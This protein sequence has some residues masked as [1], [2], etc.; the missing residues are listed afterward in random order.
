MPGMT[1][2]HVV[3][4]A[5]SFSLVLL[6]LSGA[7]ARAFCPT[8]GLKCGLGGTGVT[9]EDMTKR[10]MTELGAEFFGTPHQTRAMR[11]AIEETAQANA[12]VDEDQTNGFKH[13]DGESFAPGK[14]RLV[15]LLDGAVLS[16]RAG[17]AQGARR[18]LGQA[19][20]TLQDFYSHSN[21]LESGHTG[22]LPS[23]WRSGE[24]LPA[25]A[26]A[27]TPT[28]EDCELVILS[29]GSLFLDC[30]GNLLTPLLTSGYYGGENEVPATASKCRHGG[31]FDTGPGP[32][33]GINK[34]TLY[35][36][37]SPHFRLHTEAADSA[38]EASRQFIRDLQA[39][40]TRSE[41]ELL[42]GVGPTLT[43]AIG[44][45]GGLGGLLTLLQAQLVQLVDSRIGTD[46]EPLRYVL[47]PFTDSSTGPLTVTH[48]PIEFK[49]LLGTLVTAVGGG[50]SGPSMAAALQALGAT[51]RGGDLFLFT[52]ADSQDGHLVPRTPGGLD[53]LE[54]LEVHRALP[55]HVEGV[56][57]GRAERRGP[58]AGHGVEHRH[59]HARGE[60]DALHS[61][62]HTQHR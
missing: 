36:P 58:H 51:G 55:E 14:Q 49:R 19:L 18:Q 48:D 4:A 17:D 6:L 3:R 32:S 11:T 22:A 37:L 50:C 30:G 56:S 7:P 27:E 9:H 39:Q 54:A 62:L 20:H 43:L 23:L 52:Q 2:R 44:P 29:D 24:P 15:T 21:W 16:L 1:S 31:P 13:F 40:L 47:V 10:A 57:T 60:R 41:L 53:E 38:V 33:G 12:E 42:F 8:N 25:S 28:C 34:D 35:Q 59:Q 5:L 61:R 45:T 26:A 46:Q